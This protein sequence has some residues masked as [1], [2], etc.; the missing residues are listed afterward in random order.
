MSQD[1]PWKRFWVARGEDCHLD[2]HGFLSDPEFERGQY[3]NGH[4]TPLKKLAGI[5]F[6]GLLG[7]PG[8]GKSSEFEEAVRQ[9]EHDCAIVCD[10]Y[11]HCNLNAYS[12]EQRLIS[13]MFENSTIENWK[14]GEHRLTMFFDGLDE[15]L[16]DI[17]NLSSLLSSQFNELS[18]FVHRLH[19]RITCRTADWRMG[20]EQTAI[21]LW[22]E[23][24]VGV[25]ELAPLRRADVAAAAEFESVDG[26]HLLSE[27][28]RFDLEPFATNPV[29]LK[30]LLGI[31]KQHGSLPDSKLDLYERGCRYLCTETNR[32]RLDRGVLLNIPLDHI[33]AVASRVAAITVFCGKPSV[34]MTLAAEEGQG[35]S[36]SE[37]AGGFEQVGN[38]RIDVTEHLV[39]ETLSTKLFS[40]RGVH[41]MGF[42]H[43]TYAE[44]LGARYVTDGRMALEQ[45]RGLIFHPEMT[46]RI[47]PQLAETAAWMAMHSTKIFDEIIEENP[48][49]LLTSDVAT[50]DDKAKE[51]LVD[52]LVREL[53]LGKNEDGGWNSLDYYER[54]KHPGL[55]G[56]LK[57]IL[58]DKTQHHTTRRFICDLAE[59]CRL[60]DL[61]DALLGVLLNQTELPVVRHEAG[62]AFVAS[63]SN[64]NE[65]HVLKPFTR[66]EA[67]PDPEDDLRG[68][69][70]SA[71]WGA[72][73]IDAQ[74]IFANCLVQ[75]TNDTYFGEYYAFQERE[76]TP[77]LEP[78][79]IPFAMDWFSKCEPLG[80]LAHPF[81][82]LSQAVLGRAFTLLHL[83]HV[84]ESV[85]RFILSRLKPIDQISDPSKLTNSTSH[86]LR[87][88]LASRVIDQLPDS[89]G[90]F[91]TLNHTFPTLVQLDDIPWLIVE[92][93][94]SETSERRRRWSECLYS[95]QWRGPHAFR[96]QIIACTER[97]PETRAEFQG[98][99]GSVEVSSTEADRMRAQYREDLRFEARMARHAAKYQKKVRP[100]PKE[101]IAAYLDRFNR[102][103]MD[104]FWRLQEAM[105][106]TET[107]RLQKV[108][109]DDLTEF[110]GWEQA[111]ESTRVQ[112]LAAAEQYLGHW[113]E[114]PEVVQS[115]GVTHRPDF[116]AYRALVLCERMLPHCLGN[117]DCSTWKRLASTVVLFPSYDA[118]STGS[119]ERQR[120]LV[121][122]AYKQCPRAVIRSLLGR[123]DQRNKDHRQTGFRELRL[124]E[125]CW[126]QRLDDAVIEKVIPLVRRPATRKGAIRFNVAL[127]RQV[128][129]IKRAVARKII[130]AGPLKKRTKR[131]LSIS[132]TKDVLTSLIQKK[133][134]RGI[135]LAYQLLR[136]RNGPIAREL[137]RVSAVSLWKHLPNHGLPALLPLFRVDR[138]FFC[139]VTSDV[140]YSPG[141]HSSNLTGA[142]EGDL[143]DL[144]L[145]LVREYPYSRTS[146]ELPDLDSTE[147]FRDAIIHELRHR[148]THAACQHIERIQQLEPSLEF[149]TWI[150]QSAKKE[151]T[152]SNW[153]AMDVAEFRE[154]TAKPRNRLVRSE[155][156][157]L[158][159]VLESLDRLQTM[160]QGET[161]AVRDVWDLRVIPGKKSIA[162]GKKDNEK[163]KLEWRPVDENDF[164]DYVVRHLRRD[165]RECGIVSL[166]E[167]EL[168]RGRSE[169]GHRTDILII[170]TIQ[171]QEQSN[172]TSFRLM[173]E[174]KGCWHQELETAMQSQLLDRYMEKNHC[175][176]GIYL[177]G[178]FNCEKWTS[179]DGRQK[180]SPKLAIDDFRKQIEDQA[181]DLSMAGKT[182]KAIVVDFT[183]A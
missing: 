53:Q 5:P 26:D 145:L 63:V 86:E 132:L 112:I 22:S 58:L 151:F 24:R 14:A 155:Q 108:H 161:P 70:L 47:V 129:S 144:F 100:S 101:Q 52:Q 107:N 169:A 113:A 181:S 126:D 34:S 160:L 15:G 7:E 75:P 180:K 128:P 135:E 31:Y 141:S 83:K 109:H 68:M 110:P 102:G 80:M 89:D 37:L 64:P 175:D 167:V 82:K 51:R 152:R 168:R 73:Q 10:S 88:C 153:A 85:A 170:A 87:R 143:A 134:K 18:K 125:D 20:L 27:I 57:P 172:A 171:P 65:L 122:L 123:L 165:L 49:V 164:S 60:P 149:L 79:D 119:Q 43:R 116:A 81:E 105:M 93:D 146:D 6:L 13:K 118:I 179:Q 154:L 121:C 173:I 159:V 91:S 72:N 130:P 90:S 41:T 59:K 138:R 76:L 42:A 25:F 33:F 183:L 38:E 137:A 23:D 150:L 29:S 39:R 40:G 4:L 176:T 66:G 111:D 124:V 32:N 96:D 158:T 16:L 9:E 44:F 8:M 140:R 21:S 166:R 19:V 98:M 177:V 163:A 174:S 136:S 147:R 36:I 48:R 103:D 92:I 84:R 127:R 162:G 69:A 56:Q 117:L 148:G 97:V 74:E 142:N 62:Q 120:R 133:S 104:A 35:L 71:L 2:E 182:I 3:W 1:Y 12:S 95:L 99:F 45:Q 114:V 11:L 94:G 156:E 30:F 77:K 61:T 78:D 131:P 139:K 106:L 54:L 115:P 50:V 28:R 55:A 17:K 46:D 67:G 178:W 157:L